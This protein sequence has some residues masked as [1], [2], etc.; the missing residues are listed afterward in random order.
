MSTEPGASP[1][2]G[3]FRLEPVEDRDDGACWV[4]VWGADL[5][6]LLPR[7]LEAASQAGGGVARSSV[8]AL[9]SFAGRS[10]DVAGLVATFVAMGLA[11]PVIRASCDSAPPGEEVVGEG[12]TA[13]L[14]GETV[15]PGPDRLALEYAPKSA[16]VWSEGSVVRARFQVQPR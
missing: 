7:V 4:D 9:Q 5:A 10:N 14:R 15:V 11:T 8:R 16:R 3:G 13:V 6:E 2:K 12:A 1:F